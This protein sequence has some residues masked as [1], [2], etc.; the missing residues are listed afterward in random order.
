MNHVLTQEIILRAIETYDVDDDDHALILQNNWPRKGIKAC[1]PLGPIHHGVTTTTAP[2]SINKL[3]LEIKKNGTTH[4]ICRHI[5]PRCQFY[6]HKS[7]FG[8]IISNMILC[9]M[10]YD[11]ILPIMICQQQIKSFCTLWTHKLRYGR[12]GFCISYFYC[13]IKFSAPWN[14]HCVKSVCVRNFSGTY[15]TAFGQNTEI[16]GINLRIHSKCRKTRT[17]KFRI[18]FTQCMCWHIKWYWA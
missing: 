6:I 2:L 12:F 11:R 15:L 7:T 18:L 8:V 4:L 1:F 17:I 3:Y 16:Y 9:S 10:T 13:K 14:Y 5:K